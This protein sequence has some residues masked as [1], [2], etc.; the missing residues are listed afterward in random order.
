M[1]EGAGRVGMH[2]GSARINICD[3]MS[4]SYQCTSNEVFGGNS[5]PPLRH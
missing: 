3:E 1:A 5:R 4:A 2:E